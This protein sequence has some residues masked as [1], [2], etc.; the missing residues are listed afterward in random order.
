[1]FLE[2]SLDTETTELVALLIQEWFQGWTIIAITHNLD[3]LLH[4]DMVAVLEGGKL[5]R[6]D[7]PQKVLATTDLVEGPE[8]RSD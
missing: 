3:H 6:Y 5:V 2:N 4:Y 8:E 1:M 7:T